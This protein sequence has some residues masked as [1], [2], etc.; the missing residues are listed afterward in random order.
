MNPSTLEASLVT[1]YR[2]SKGDSVIVRVYALSKDYYSFLNSVELAK[3]V[4]GNP[5]VQPAQVVSNIITVEI[6]GLAEQENIGYE[7][8]DDYSIKLLGRPLINSN[9]S[10]SYLY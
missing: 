7:L 8:V 1:P 2:F 4:N 3:Q 5:F 9:V 10:I 6:N